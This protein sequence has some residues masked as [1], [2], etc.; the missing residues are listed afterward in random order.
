MTLKFIIFR[1]LRVKLEL[2]TNWLRFEIYYFVFF[3]FTLKSWTKLI[4]EQ[5]LFVCV[6]WSDPHA[7][8]KPGL[9]SLIVFYIEFNDL[10]NV[11][12]SNRL[13]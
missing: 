6:R 12:S 1:N 11:H 9:S 5:E 7:H 4:S 8:D 2:A 10:L 3:Y 13:V